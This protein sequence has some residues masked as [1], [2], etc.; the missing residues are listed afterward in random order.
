L[1]SIQYWARPKR[2][3]SLAKRG[4]CHAGAAGADEELQRRLCAGHA[5]RI[6]VIGLQ[7]TALVERCVHHVE[8]PFRAT[9]TRSKHLKSRSAA[10]IARFDLIEQGSQARDVHGR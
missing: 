6:V 4:F 1:V 8:R 3:Q 7:F 9:V 5:E 2:A 10:A